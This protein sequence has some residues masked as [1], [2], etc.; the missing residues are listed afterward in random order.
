[1][2]RIKAATSETFRSFRVRNFRVFF[3]GQAISQVGTWLQFI[4]QALLVLK[5]TDSGVALGL[6][7]AFQFLPVLVFGAWAGVISDRVD[8]RKLMLATQAAMM[9]F[10]LV[11]GVFVLS[12]HITV[13]GVYVLAVLTGTANAFDN[14]SRRVVITELVPESEM[15]NAVSLN[16]ALITGSRVVGPATAAWLINSVGIGWCFIANSASFVAMLI[17]LVMIDGDELYVNERIEKK[18]GQIAEGFRYVWANPDLRLA[19]VLMGVVATLSFNWQVLLP[20]LAEHELH[21]NDNTYAFITTVFSVGSLAGSLLIARRTS[22][23]NRLLA[24]A[25]VG[26]GIS[27]LLV[28][29][30]PTP[31]TAG[32]AGA[33]AG[34]TGIAFLS[35]TMTALQLNSVPSMRGR[36]MAL[37][38]ILFLGSTPFGGPLAG[39][40]AQVYGTRL[41]IAVG[42]V[43]ALTSGFA[44][45]VVLRQRALRRGFAFEPTPAALEAAA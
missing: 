40:L 17:A 4:A 35:A 15:A 9:V 44:G 31:V 2:T 18:K 45:L 12:G 14:P 10:A 27:S 36:V 16:S 33:L 26:L 38:T 21:G 19:M 13:A 3:V 22:M 37:Y 20:L 34:A 8:K 28:A 11:L 5:L 43:A 30:A 32:L 23:D 24:R 7:T 25:C 39:W 41:S 29:V 42:A 1:M 6:V